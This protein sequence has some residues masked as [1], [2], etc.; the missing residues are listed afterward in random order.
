MRRRISGALRAERRLAAGAGW[1]NSRRRHAP[2]GRV[3][4][5][6]EAEEVHALAADH[7][8]LAHLA[9]DH[10]HSFNRGRRAE[11]FCGRQDRRDLH[12]QGARAAVQ[13][14]RRRRGGAK[15]APHASRERNSCVR[16][17][18]LPCA[19]GAHPLHLRAPRPFSA[20]AQ[21]WE[22]P[23]RVAAVA[24]AAS[25]RGAR[26]TLSHPPP[27]RAARRC[28]RSLQRPWARPRRRASS[29][30]SSGAPL[31]RRCATPRRL[32]CPN[33]LTPMR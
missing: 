11:H 17:G 18:H 3:V 32:V 14:A 12:P 19:G 1:P 29:R 4:R 23:A 15:S 5:L 16:W 13:D 6:D 9:V 24:G 27:R 8:L 10:G 28:A 25:R 7:E 30:R 21:R 31:P 22:A 2:G 20:P 26:R 33:A